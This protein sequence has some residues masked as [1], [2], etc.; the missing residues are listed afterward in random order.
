MK[1]YEPEKPQRENH[2]GIMCF[3]ANTI[4]SL[5]LKLEFPFNM[6]RKKVYLKR[7]TTTIFIFGIISRYHGKIR[8]KEPKNRTCLK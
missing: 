3:P 5:F 4:K 7:P 1:D 6:I 8:Y 2:G